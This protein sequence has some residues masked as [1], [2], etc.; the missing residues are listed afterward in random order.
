MQD[1]LT[2]PSLPQLKK[3]ADCHVVVAMIDGLIRSGKT[4]NFLNIWKNCIQ[5][6][7]IEPNIS[8][9]QVALLAAAHNKDKNAIRHFKFI[10][11]MKLMLNEMKNKENNIAFNRGWAHILLAYS[12]MGDFDSMWNEYYEYKDILSRVDGKPS[13]VILSILCSKSTY[14]KIDNTDKQIEHQKRGIEECKQ[15]I[16]TKQDWNHL[17]QKE[18]KGFYLAACQTDND[19]LRSILKPRMND[20][21]K[22]MRKEKRERKLNAETHDN[23][24]KYNDKEYPIAR[25][26]IEDEKVQQQQGEKL[27]QKTSIEFN[28][29]IKR[30]DKSLLKNVRK[31]IQSTNHEIDTFQLTGR[32]LTNQDRKKENIMF[33]CEKK[34]LAYMINLTKDNSHYKTINI[35]TNLR[36]C[37][38]CH[39]FFCAVSKCFSQKQIILTD[40]KTKHLFEN[41]HCSCR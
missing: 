27:R 36:M 40:P 34:A 21:D 5:R 9:Y 19:E 31:L 3:L 7:K 10:D 38:D 4:Q 26:L 39:R 29:L 11:E 8:C 28:N 35:V 41:G 16:P 6:C 25:C 13:P 23:S 30:E 12:K 24:E 1:I 14:G 20:Y 15:F 33:H 37:D 22:Q 2:T 18:I 32:G 17:N